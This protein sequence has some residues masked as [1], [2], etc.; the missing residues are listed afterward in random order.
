[1]DEILFKLSR[2]LKSTLPLSLIFLAGLGSIAAQTRSASNFQLLK[3]SQNLIP[4]PQ[5][6]YSKAEQCQANQRDRWLEVEVQFSSTPEFT[7]ELT[8]KYFIVSNGKLLTGEVTHVNIPA[9]C[10]NRSV[11]YAAPRSLA[12][13][14]GSWVVSV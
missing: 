12:R 10:K 1:L 9:G 14:M 7:D 5:Y 4:P 3:I 2:H 11:I 8:F 13:F 6:T